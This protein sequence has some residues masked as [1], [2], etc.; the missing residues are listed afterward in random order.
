MNIFYPEVHVGYICFIGILYFAHNVVLKSR[1]V[2]FPAYD[3]GIL[4]YH[5]K[6]TC[7]KM[8]LGMDFNSSQINSK[9]ITD[10]NEI[11]NC[12]TPRR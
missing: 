3:T 1:K 12:K 6:N 2:V 11:Q 10:Q 5:A 4:G 9:W 8:N 7:K